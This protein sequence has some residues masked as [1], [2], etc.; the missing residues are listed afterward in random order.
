MPGIVEAAQHLGVHGVLLL[1]PID[2]DGQDVTVL[3]GEQRGL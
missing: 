1:G 2:R 3:L